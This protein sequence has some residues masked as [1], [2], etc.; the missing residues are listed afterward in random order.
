MHF[1]LTDKP[2]PTTAACACMYMYS[3]HKQA[4]KINK[5]NNACMVL[6]DRGLQTEALLPLHRFLTSGFAT[7]PFQWF[8]VVP[9]LDPFSVNTELLCCFMNASFILPYTIAIS[10]FNT[11]AIHNTCMN[12]RSQISFSGPSRMEACNGGKIALCGSSPSK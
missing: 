8:I 4:N 12:C 2:P 11:L 6:D 7:V 1:H 5:D 9:F 3:V 10:S